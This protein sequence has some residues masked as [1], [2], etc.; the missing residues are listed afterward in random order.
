MMT[1]FLIVFS[2]DSNMRLCFHF[3]MSPARIT[4][5]DILHLLYNMIF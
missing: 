1:L 5:A 4:I 3:L 2:Y